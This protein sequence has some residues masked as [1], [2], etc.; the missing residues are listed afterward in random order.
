M[1]IPC[2]RQFPLGR[3]EGEARSADTAGVPLI[4]KQ[5]NSPATLVGR[6][7][8]K[9]CRTVHRTSEQ[10]APGGTEMAR[11]LHLQE[12]CR[13]AGSLIGGSSD[14]ETLHTAASQARILQLQEMCQ[15]GVPRHEA[16][17]TPN[18]SS[19]PIRLIKSVEIVAY[20]ASCGAS[21][22]H[23]RIPQRGKVLC[24]MLLFSQEKL[25][26]INRDKFSKWDNG[27]VCAFTIR[28]PRR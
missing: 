27:D 22:T 20:R 16:P 24:N 21:G 28:A 11:K 19:G 15:R 17:S 6:G 13:P 12:A 3:S 18:I 26:R 9:C 10:N 23:Q 25:V 4:L 2:Q 1:Q 7:A 5:V 8:T 14:A